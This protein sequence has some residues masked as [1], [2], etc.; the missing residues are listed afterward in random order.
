MIIN[1][2][3]TM[4]APLLLFAYN[5]R[6]SML[7]HTFSAEVCTAVQTKLKKSS[8]ESKE[9]DYGSSDRKFGNDI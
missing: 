7:M 6:V 2:A 9:N 8:P 4:F 1:G 5:Q 3:D